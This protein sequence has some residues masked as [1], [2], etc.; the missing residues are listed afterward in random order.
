[1]LGPSWGT[2]GGQERPRRHTEAEALCSLGP[3]GSG[4][5]S[6]HLGKHAY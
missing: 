4:K 1:M 5:S 6:R 2:L 3:H